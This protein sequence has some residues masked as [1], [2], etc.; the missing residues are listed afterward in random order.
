MPVSAPNLLEYF[1]LLIFNVGECIYFLEYFC[2]CI[3]VCF[4]SMSA[5]PA[6]FLFYAFLLETVLCVC[7]VRVRTIDLGC[8]LEW[9][10]PD[11]NPNTTYTVEAKTNGWVSSAHKEEAQKHMSVNDVEDV[12]YRRNESEKRRAEERWAH[13]WNSVWFSRKPQSNTIQAYCPKVDRLLLSPQAHCWFPLNQN[14]KRKWLTN[15]QAQFA[16]YSFFFL[17]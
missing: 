14:W 13:R 7:D 17:I 10:C 16:L 8:H 9:D 2:L 4:Q 15:V 1:F 6:I 11:A 3:S 12:V 5:I